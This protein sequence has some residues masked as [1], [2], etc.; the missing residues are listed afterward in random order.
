M[1]STTR[2]GKPRLRRPKRM[3]KIETVQWF[4]AN[5]LTIMPDDCWH[6]AIA[7][8]NH[9]RAII[10]FCLNGE[11]QSLYASRLFYEVLVGPIPADLCAC[12]RCDNPRCVNP[13]HI[14]L[15]TQAVN[16]GDAASKSRMSQ[17]EN[18]RD[19]KLT[20]TQVMQI[21]LLSEAGYEK[22][23]LARMFDCNPST[24]RSIVLGITWKHVP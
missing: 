8:N 12:H 15:A 13:D 18:H 2:E 11:R 1:K 23:D 6:L 10:E 19:A 4:M 17:G 21:R 20:E 16:M 9:G 14:F 24:I 7:D 3:S 5:R 22:S